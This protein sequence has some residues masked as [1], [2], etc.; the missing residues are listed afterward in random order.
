MLR[1]SKTS[2]GVKNVKVKNVKINQDRALPPPCTFQT[3]SRQQGRTVYIL[4]AVPTMIR[5]FGSG[6]DPND[7]ISGRVRTVERC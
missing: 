5:W 3:A 6:F 4:E 2:E 7:T 1:G